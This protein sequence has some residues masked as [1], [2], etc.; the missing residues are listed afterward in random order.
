MLEVADSA[1]FFLEHD[2]HGWLALAIC[3]ARY[4]D[5]GGGQLFAPDGRD[6]FL[7]Y[8]GALGDVLAGAL[9]TLVVMSA[10]SES[11]T[12]LLAQD[13]AA[14]GQMT[15]CSGERF[16]QGGADA[17][18]VLMRKLS[19]RQAT[20]LRRRYFPESE[21]AGLRVG[22]RTFHRDNSAALTG[23]FLDR[24]QEWAS[25]LDL[26]LPDEQAA[27]ARDFSVR[28][29]NGV[30]GCGKTLIAL[31]RAIL[32][33]QSRP[34][35]QVLLLIHNTHVVADLMERMHR[36]HLPIPAN[37][38]MFTFAKWAIRQWKAVFGRYPQMPKGHELLGMV[39]ALQPRPPSLGLDDEQ[40]LEEMNF[41]NEALISGEAGYLAAD[42][43]GRG[44][45]LR[46][47][48]R[49]QV[50]ALF[51]QLNAQLRA[52]GWRLWSAIAGEIC[53][54]AQ[55]RRDTRAF[56]TFATFDHILVDE[57]QFMAPASLQL[58]KLAL[59]PGGSMFLCA[60]PRQG[61]LKNRLSWKR[62]GLAVAGRTKK[63]RRSY[64]TTKALL[65]AATRMLAR[66]VEEDPEDYLAPDFAGMDE[67]VPPM[68]VTVDTPQDAVDRV[69]NEIAGLARQSNFPL[70][71]ILVMYGGRVSKDLLYAS[72]C[73]RIGAAKVWWLNK[74]RAAPPGGYGAEHI[75]M[76]SIDT[77][78][79][80]E[81]TFVFLLGVEELLSLG[82]HD[83]G[84]EV[85]ARKL[86]MAMTRSCY[87]LSVVT[88]Q[89]LPDEALGDI[90]E[91]RA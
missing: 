7:R 15:L 78:T 20:V 12:A 32:L 81:G 77:A 70:S 75:R 26:A 52:R 47:I 64:R 89:A 13:A 90:F 83:R 54:A 18:R 79:G 61:F 28:L 49:S 27:L 35:Q 40:L 2:E 48:E 14:G 1:D 85:R 6:A 42:R 76:A 19:A 41:L 74:D 25:K 50:W 86:Y 72:L 82:G 22:R 46:E 24:E 37:M 39:R 59:R 29:L 51:Q 55:Q 21:I 30:A 66:Q 63:L 69:A 4:A 67:G 3:P 60:D 17:L 87:R 68:L 10:C 5:I 11:D 56:A 62:V 71:S 8:L 43:A 23:V 57:A 88:A 53:D 16:A 34:D 73:Q 44:F 9:P 58:I 33:A 65:Q 91:R 45:A 31:Q 84:T 38:Q 36:G 80:L